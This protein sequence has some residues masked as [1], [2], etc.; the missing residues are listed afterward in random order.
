VNFSFTR[1]LALSVLG[2]GASLSSAYAGQANFHLPFDAH[3][4]T[5]TLTPGD[6]RI[7]LPEAAAPV[8]VFYVKGQSAQGL[9]LAGRFDFGEAGGKSYLKLVN[10]NGEY[11]VREYVSGTSGKT[12]TFLVPK[13]THRQQISERILSVNSEGTK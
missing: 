12:F 11:F 2:I 7:A 5:L 10:V 4:G 9:E 3:W 6:Y 8:A 1:V 13:A